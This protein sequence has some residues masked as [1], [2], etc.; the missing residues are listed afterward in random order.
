MRIA[1]AADGSVLLRVRH[2]P[3][4][5]AARDY[6][7]SSGQGI[8]VPVE[9]EDAAQLWFEPY[10][11]PPGNERAELTPPN[12]VR[13]LLTRIGR[14]RPVARDKAGAEFPIIEEDGRQYL[15]FPAAARVTLT[16]A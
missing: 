16:Y 1:H 6:S 9:P 15:A 7:A 3:P 11:T 13:V 12:D 8:D 10:P 2:L 14:L 5:G 4:S